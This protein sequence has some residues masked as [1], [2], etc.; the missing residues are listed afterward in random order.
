MTDDKKPITLPT[1]TKQQL[2]ALMDK[3]LG[4]NIVAEYSSR[5]YRICEASLAFERWFF[6]VFQPANPGIHDFELVRVTNGT[7]EGMELGCFNPRFSPDALETIFEAYQSEQ[8]KAAPVAP[9]GPEEAPLPD[10]VVKFI[11]SIK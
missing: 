7:D 1:E 9:I 4:A 3:I 6:D 5:V 10:N 2:E 8:D 11:K